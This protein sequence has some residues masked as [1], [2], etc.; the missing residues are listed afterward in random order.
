MS[1]GPV[2]ELRIAAFRGRKLAIRDKNLFS[3]GGSSDP[4]L[5]FACQRPAKPSIHSKPRL[6]KTTLD[7][8]WKEQFC[9]FPPN[10]RTAVAAVRCK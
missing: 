4:K 8:V 1:D 6:N 3:A 7:P 2:N 9:F 10:R 5:T